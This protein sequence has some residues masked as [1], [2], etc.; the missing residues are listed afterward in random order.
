MNTDPDFLDA[1]S[2]A[3]ALYSSVLRLAYSNPH[4]SREIHEEALLMLR[5]IGCAMVS[6]ERMSDVT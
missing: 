1:E 3:K 2:H 6:I 4:S 5:D